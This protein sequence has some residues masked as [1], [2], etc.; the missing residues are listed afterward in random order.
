MIG[1]EVFFRSRVYEPPF[2]PYYDAYKGHK[3]KVVKLHHG[4]HI[5]LTCVSDPTV[6]VNGYVHVEDLKRA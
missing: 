3:F 4:D 1:M 5:E 6:K 2:S